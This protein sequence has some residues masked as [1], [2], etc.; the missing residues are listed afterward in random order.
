M[1]DKKNMRFVAIK[2]S[3]IKK[4][5]NLVFVLIGLGFLWYV[6]LDS[7]HV[8]W[9]QE[10]FQNNKSKPKCIYSPDLN[11]SKLYFPFKVFINIVVQYR[12][13]DKSEVYLIPGFFL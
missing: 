9:K 10:I 4:L 6:E 13:F 7:V 1:F 8:Y 3:K 2:L 5:K 11:R 12:S